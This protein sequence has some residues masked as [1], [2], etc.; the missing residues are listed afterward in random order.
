MSEPGGP[1]PPGQTVDAGVLP[2]TAE[3]NAHAHLVIGGCDVVDLIAEFGSPLYVYD[4][5]T[6]RMRCRQ[7]TDRK[8]VV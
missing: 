1:I 6:I 3:V 7:Y 2:I 8:S 5:Q 4:E